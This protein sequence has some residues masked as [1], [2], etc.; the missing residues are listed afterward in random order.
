MFHVFKDGDE[1]FDLNTL[2]ANT[3]D[4]DAGI[5]GRAR[6]EGDIVT[7]TKVNRFFESD[8]DQGTRTTVSGL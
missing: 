5:L 8:E 3:Q 4:V 1:I 6:Y 2:T 7:I